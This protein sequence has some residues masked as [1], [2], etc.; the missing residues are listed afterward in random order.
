MIVKCL[1]MGIW[2]SSQMVYQLQC[3]TYNLFSSPLLQQQQQNESQYSLLLQFSIT[4]RLK[5]SNLN[6]QFTF[7]IAI[8]HLSRPLRGREAVKNTI[9]SWVVNF[10]VSMLIE[11]PNKKNSKQ[12]TCTAFSCHQ[13]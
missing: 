11:K 2:P 8:N 10:R 4:C 6:Q 12:V 13:N 7:F 9:V 3:K 5:N 1:V